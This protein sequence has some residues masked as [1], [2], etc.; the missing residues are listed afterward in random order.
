MRAA[1]IVILL[2]SAA[3]GDATALDR[4]MGFAQAL[5]QEQGPPSY[6]ITVSRSCECM[7]ETTAPAVVEVTDGI[8][9]SRRYVQSGEVVPSQYA[10][11]FP[12]ID[13]LFGII[14]AA[15][16]DRVAQLD[17]TYDPTWGYPTR[18]SIDREANMVDDEV[19]ISARAFEPREE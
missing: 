17:V 11:W 13:G 3:C 10:E 12:T 7:P 1:L 8:V 4:R 16:R 6:R 14:E 5:W 18:I 15:R 2:A 9:T 19:V